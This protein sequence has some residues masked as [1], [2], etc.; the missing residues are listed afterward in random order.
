MLS[1]NFST[2]LPPSISILRLASLSSLRFYKR[3]EITGF[4]SEMKAKASLSS[5]AGATFERYIK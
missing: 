5:A 4:L 3:I 2:D 1:S